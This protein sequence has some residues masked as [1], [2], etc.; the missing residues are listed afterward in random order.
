MPATITNH[1]LRRSLTGRSRPGQPFGVHDLDDAWCTPAQQSYAQTYQA[2]HAG[3]DVHVEIQT[4]VGGLMAPALHPMG[5]DARWLA[6][7]GRAEH[8]MLGGMVLLGARVLSCPVHPAV[9]EHGNRLEVCLSNSPVQIACDALD[10]D[11]LIINACELAEVFYHEVHL[12]DGGRYG[13]PVR[14][15]DPAWQHAEL[16]RDRMRT[17]MSSAG[18]V[19]ASE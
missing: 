4:L 3:Q 19:V 10:A 18:A 5:Y 15:V 8:V 7:K 14:H 17:A 2:V 6:L 16:C 9:D 1:E 11:P 12:G 13:P